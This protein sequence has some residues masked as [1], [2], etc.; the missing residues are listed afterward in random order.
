MADVASSSTI[1][2]KEMPFMPARLVACV[3]KRT[4]NV[5]PSGGKYASTIAGG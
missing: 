2:H 3:S 1:E 5:V 4:T